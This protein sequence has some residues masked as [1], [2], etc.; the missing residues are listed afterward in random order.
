MFF[1]DS[2]EKDEDRSWEEKVSRRFAADADKR[3]GG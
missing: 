1:L 2:P 3:N